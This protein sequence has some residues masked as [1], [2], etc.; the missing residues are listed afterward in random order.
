MGTLAAGDVRHRL[1]G[2][3]L[4]RTRLSW[5]VEP[6]GRDRDGADGAWS[7][8]HSFVKACALPLCYQMAWFVR[9]GGANPVYSHPQLSD[10]QG[11]VHRTC[12][13]KLL[14]KLIV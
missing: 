13:K 1:R 6:G 2:R 12:R 14:Q 10:L 5:R 4:T 7:R 9:S 3:G 11:H 8:L